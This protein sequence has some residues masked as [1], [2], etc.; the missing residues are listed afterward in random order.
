MLAHLRVVEVISWSRLR[1]LSLRPQSTLL[2]GRQPWRYI[3][4]LY[5]NAFSRCC[6]LLISNIILRILIVM[7]RVEGMLLFNN[8]FANWIILIVSGFLIEVKVDH[9]ILSQ[10]YIVV[11]TQFCKNRV[12]LVV[13][14][15]A[16]I[17]IFCS[18]STEKRSLHRVV[19]FS[20]Q[21]VSILGKSISSRSLNFHRLATSFG[22]E[23]FK[24]IGYFLTAFFILTAHFFN[25]IFKVIKTS[26]SKALPWYSTVMVALLVL[27]NEGVLP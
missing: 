6:V 2:V 21:V 19:C 12:I 13:N 1:L 26:A 23:Y 14:S 25:R 18:V 15:N 20:C 9:A 16:L 24:F 11:F 8:A 3:W 4:L 22:Q 27:T 5:Q 10:G 7:R 17:V